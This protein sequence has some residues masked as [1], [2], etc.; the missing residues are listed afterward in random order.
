MIE[1]IGNKILIFIIIMLPVMAV[2][3][4]C[5]NKTRYKSQNNISLEVIGGVFVSCFVGAAF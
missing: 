5:A 4:G 1:I 3:K 2:D